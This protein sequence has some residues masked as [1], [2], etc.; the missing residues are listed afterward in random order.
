MTYSDSAYCEVSDAQ[1]I[2][3]VRQGRSEAFEEIVRR[4]QQNVAA[5]VSALLYRHQEAEDIVQQVF[6][7]VFANLDTFREGHDFGRWVRAI[8]RNAV[9][10]QLRKQTRY[11]R[12]LQTYYE[13]LAARLG[14]ESSSDDDQLRS[15]FLRECLGQLRG[16]AAQ[17]IHWR[18]TDGRGIS[19]IATSL[20][21]TANAISKLL[22]R[23][24]VALRQCVER[25]MA[26]P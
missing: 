2:H 21:T 18:Y 10:E 17:V 20:K 6:V 26:E 22:A 24:R 12:R 13:M 4:Y 25:K 9:R 19:E 8:A 5:V 1:L 11:D 16:K 15:A 23:T 3:F 14:N 7:N